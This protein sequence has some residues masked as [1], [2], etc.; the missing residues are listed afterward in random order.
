MS[1]D[2]NLTKLN[3]FLFSSPPIFCGLE[4]NQKRQEIGVF[5]I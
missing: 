1:G 5:G 3:F 4:K 2:Y